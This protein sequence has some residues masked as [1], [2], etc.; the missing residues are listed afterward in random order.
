MK[1]L[2]LA[3]VA[4]LA[5]CASPRAPAPARPVQRAAGAVAGAGRSACALPPQPAFP[6]SDA[7]LASALGLAERVVRLRQGRDARIEYE[8]R[9]REACR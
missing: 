7:G 6:D 3:L 2:A 4:L 5:A 8:R 1:R 9:L